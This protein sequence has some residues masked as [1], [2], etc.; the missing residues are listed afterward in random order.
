MRKRDSRDKSYF[1]NARGLNRAKSIGWGGGGEKDL[2]MH[3]EYPP[4]GK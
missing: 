2:E 4:R 1:Q 3:T